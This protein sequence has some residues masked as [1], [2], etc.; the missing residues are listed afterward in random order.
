MK[1]KLICS[2]CGWIYRFIWPYRFTSK[3]PP[4]PICDSHMDGIRILTYKNR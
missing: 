1:S 3:I 2:N 4:C